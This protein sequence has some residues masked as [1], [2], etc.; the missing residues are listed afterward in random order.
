MSHLLEVLENNVDS[1]PKL[2]CPALLLPHLVH[3]VL[4]WAVQLCQLQ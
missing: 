2:A 1:F 4:R 3:S